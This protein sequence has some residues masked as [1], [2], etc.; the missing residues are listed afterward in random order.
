MVQTLHR[1]F[2]LQFG[3]PVLQE[4]GYISLI[5]I[6]QNPWKQSLTTSSFIQQFELNFFRS[7][8][9]IKITQK[10]WETKE[11]TAFSSH[12]LFNQI[13]PRYCNLSSQKI[14]NYQDHLLPA[15]LIVMTDNQPQ[16]QWHVAASQVCMGQFC[17]ALRQ[18]QN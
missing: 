8:R 1:E 13:Q 12:F 10:R 18:I 14:K 4:T 6:T 5:F 11:G 3:M 17:L 15:V 16:R 2:H 7:K 9:K